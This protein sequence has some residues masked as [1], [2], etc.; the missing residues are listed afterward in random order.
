[1]TRQDRSKCIRDQVVMVLTLV[2]QRVTFYWHATKNWEV[3]LEISATKKREAEISTGLSIMGSIC[4]PAKEPVQGLL[5][6]SRS[7][8]SRGSLPGKV[9]TRVANT[10]NGFKAKI[11]IG[12]GKFMPKGDHGTCFARFLMGRPGTKIDQFHLGECRE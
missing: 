2:L 12:I 5:D 6:S 11:S 7:R 4:Y 3:F 8:A 10:Y 9:A 1:M